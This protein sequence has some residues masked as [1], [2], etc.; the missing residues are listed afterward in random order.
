MSSNKI[1]EYIANQPENVQLIL[2][3]IRSIIKDLVPDA[4]EKINYDIPA[5]SLIKGGKRDRQIMFAAFKS[6]SVFIHFQ[7]QLN[8]SEAS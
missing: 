3:K 8:I 5:I 1:D 7:R 4:E 2:E 6:T